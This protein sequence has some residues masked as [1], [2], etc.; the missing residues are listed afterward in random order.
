MRVKCR[1]IETCVAVAMMTL[2]PLVALASTFE[3]TAAVQT[4]LDKQKQVVAGW[5]ADPIIVGA[6]KAQNRQ[7][8]IEGMDNPKWKTT[9]RSDSVV[10]SLQ[11]NAAGQ[12]LRAKLEASGGTFNEAFL[13]GARGEKVAFVEKT[14]S[15]I[16]VGQAK[17]D[18]PF[19][20]SKSWQGKPEFDESSQTYAIQ[21]SVPVLDGGQPIGSLVVGVN[22]SHLEKVAKK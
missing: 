17:H 6:V 8:P 20:T 15:Y 5:A 9:R 7:G 18:V 12:A 10:K 22:L 16:H 21:I 1:F 13:N 3:I 11:S 14:T 2:L 19:G 4:E